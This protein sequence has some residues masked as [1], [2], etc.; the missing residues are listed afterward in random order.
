MLVFRLTSSLLVSTLLALSIG[1]AQTPG[2]IKGVV[3]DE[4]GAVVPAA[5]VSLTGKGVQKA[6]Q[7][8]ADG[9]YT[10]TGLAAGQYTVHAAVPGFSPFDKQVTVAGGAT[11]SLE[12]PLHV[13]SEKQEVTV[14]ADPGPSV[15][16]EPDNNATALVLKGE[17]LAALPDD[18]DDLQDALQALAGPAAGPNGG[19]LYVDGFSGGNLPPKESIREIRINQNP[20]SAEY[21]RLGFGRIEI[22]TKPGTDRLRGSLFFNDSVGALNSRN[23]FVTNKPDYSNRMFGVNVGGP[24]G[25]RASFFFDFNRRDITDNA[26]VHATFLDPASLQAQ[27]IDTAVV[28]PNTRTTLSPRIDY[29]LSTNHT[30][31][32][33]MEYGWNSRDNTGIGGFSLPPSLAPNLAYNTTGRNLNLMVTETAVLNPTVVNETRFQFARTSSGSAGNLLPQ[34]NV[35]GAFVTGGNGVG[36]TFNLGTHYELQNYT[37]IS[38]GPHTIRFGGRLRRMA[39]SVNSPSGFGGT[40]QFFGGLGP[41]LGPDNQPVIDPATGQVETEQLTSIEQYRRTLAFQNLGFSPAAIRALG[42]GASQFTIAGGNPFA[43]VVQY[44]AGPFVQDDWRVRSNFTLSLG[45]RYEV[46]TNVS[47]Y[48]D[49]A[50]RVG[51]AWAPGSAKNGRQK[52]VIRGGFGIFYDRIADNLTLRA[53]QLNG[54]NQLQFVVQNPDFFPNIPS[55]SALTPAQN[56]TYRLDA[57]LHAP[58]TLQTAIGI[59]RQLPHNTTVAVTYT[60]TRGVHLLQT[61]NINSPLPGTFVTGQT[62]SGLRPYGGAGNLFLYESGGLLTQHIVMANFNT[63]FT[64][65]VSL[66]GNYALNWAHDLPGT[67][68]NPYDFAQ[69]WGRSLLDRRHRFQLVGSVAAPFGLRLNPFVTLQSGSPYDVLIGH[70]LNGDTLQNDRPAA[71][72]GTGP[73]VVATQ[74]GFFNINPQN[75][76]A[77]VT[78]NLLTTA[79]LVSVNLRIGRTFGFGES[80]APGAGAAG[81]GG[82]RGGFGGPGGRGGPGGPG[83]GGGMRMGP[84]AGRGGGFGETT[85]HRYNLTLSLM[86]NNF[87][88]HVNPGGYTGILSSP[89]FGLPST[90]NSGFGGGGPGGGG[91]GGGGGGGFGGAVANNRRI[92]LQMRFSF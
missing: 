42:G 27:E 75:G 28:T 45:L 88:N 32:A 21:D 37:S 5:A 46:Q 72:A 39:T 10:F 12:I 63:R 59:E 8:Q 25:K 85:D 83:G 60:N 79:G 47:D 52:T 40:F 23:P 62:G 87:L 30:L 53:L 77:P 64:R 7:S 22:L 24:L 33:R 66:F 9:S 16:V 81:G 50:P 69:D 44:D 51:F 84:P 55:L 17:D 2:A 67:P 49:I 13:T 56:S 68:S 29:Q 48:H 71:A 82:G 14:Q 65:S 70:D 80:R 92:E 58:M 43:S 35:S 89:Q 6:V 73:G 3:T 11:V 57:N 31:V 20:F 78:R 41:V 26:I 86:F 15:S 1:Y 90:L 19:Q 76:Q 18:P 36:D 54:F 4:S 74:F 34:I 61:V 38:R 91:P